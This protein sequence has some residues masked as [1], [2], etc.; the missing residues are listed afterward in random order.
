MVFFREGLMIHPLAMP[1]R[2]RF[3]LGAALLVSMVGF[4][5]CAHPQTRGQS[6]D[7]RD[8]DL[9]IRTIGD[10]TE[11]GNVAP[12]AISGVGLVTGLNGTGG[13]PPGAFRKMLEEQLLKQNCE[14][15]KQMLEST[16]NALVLVSAVIPAGARKGELLDI[17]VML[18]PGS[19]ATSL[20]GGYLELSTMRDYQASQNLNPN[21]KAGNRLLTG[22]ILAHARGALLVGF[23]GKNDDDMVRQARIWGGGV[24]HIDRPFFLFMNKDQ[25]FASVANSVAQRI[26][27][28]FP[29]DAVKRQQVLRNKN[30]LV[31]DDVTQQINA[32]FNTPNSVHSTAKALSKELV[33]I[34]VPYLYRFNPQRYLRVVRLI[35]LQ[36]ANGKGE[37][38]RKRLQEMLGDPKYAVR[39]ALR[40]EALGKESV[41][42]LKEALKSS[43]PLVR[44]CAAEALAYLGSTA[45]CEQLTRLADSQPLLRAYCLLALSSLEEGVC[46][47]D[48][49]DMLSAS[50]AELRCG[51]FQALR[52]I[53]DSD[54]RLNG[55]S[56]NNGFWL[57]Q[58]APGS[59]PMVYFSVR[60]RAEVVLFGSDIHLTPPVKVLAG[61]EFTITADVGDDRCTVGRFSP[62]QSPM[63]KQCSL[64]LDDV[65]RTMGELGATYAD[66]VD[67]LTKAD[68]RHCLSCPVRFRSLP[69]EVSVESLAQGGS[70]PNFLK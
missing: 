65:L 10:I 28:M 2:R 7:E 53:D 64:R 60:Q 48:L 15:V 56:I 63:R 37:R 16:D 41:P 44:F 39:A 61:P 17:D 68:Q 20:R 26:N 35:P 51:A 9:D 24:S 13:S 58:V 23:D 54:K 55:E 19:K 3:A 32:K 18:P 62:Q 70:D 66:A 30:L 8:K 27:I 4:L 43:Q 14:H 11:V 36:E 38:Y 31:L 40:L 59:P 12:L 46:R 6:A 67:L 69:E 22:H 52:M 29:D 47:Q 42:A 25:T 21:D 50:D 49:T 34:N 33:D 45:G 5:G 57:H 1:R